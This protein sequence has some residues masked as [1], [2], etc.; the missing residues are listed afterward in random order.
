MGM[1]FKG[2]YDRFRKLQKERM[3]GR[4]DDRFAFVNIWNSGT[5]TATNGTIIASIRIAMTGSAR[6]AGIFRVII[7]PEKSKKIIRIAQILMMCSISMK[8]PQKSR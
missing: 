7:R 2:R 4:T 5:R 6:M 3:G 8:I 1:P